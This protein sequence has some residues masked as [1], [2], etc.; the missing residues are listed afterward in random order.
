MLVKVG[1][2]PVVSQWLCKLYPVRIWLFLDFADTDLVLSLCVQR[3][4]CLLML[5]EVV[6]VEN[7]SVTLLA[8]NCTPIQHLL[9]DYLPK[10]SRPLWFHMCDVQ[11]IGL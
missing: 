10:L 5:C 11:I 9:K 8:L 3:V 1:L 2:P 6:V 7:E 4:V